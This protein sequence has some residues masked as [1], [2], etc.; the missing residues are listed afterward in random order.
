MAGS[1]RE[2]VILSGELS[3]DLLA[4]ALAAEI[5]K[6]RPDW[7]LVGAGGPH[8]RSAGVDLLYNSTS[9]SAI[10]FAQSVKLIPRLSFALADIKAYIAQRRP[11]RVVLVDFG[12]FNIRV[13]RSAKKC[14]VPVCYYVPPGSWRRGRADSELAHV[15]DLVLTPFPWSAEELRLQGANAHWIGHPLLDIVRPGRSRND[16]LCEAGLSEVEVVFG[17]LPGSRKPELLALTPLMARAAVIIQNRCRR[18]GFLLG[19]ASTTD[20]RLLDRLL[21]S[22]GWIP[23]DPSA[24][25][26]KIRRYKAGAAPAA[27][28]HGAPYDVMAASDIL[29]CCSGTATLEA[30]ILQKPMIIA[31]RTH[32]V[33]Q[34]LEYALGRRLLPRY[35]G[36]PNLLADAEVCPEFLQHRASPENLA[37]EALDIIRRGDRLSD[38]LRG[39][40]E[41]RSI[42][43]EQGASARAAELI[44]DPNLGRGK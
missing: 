25:S 28:V 43:G 29:L 4:G 32:G 36:L 34:A 7:H 9:W 31:Y 6:R 35:I 14:G 12:T 21:R 38:M 22:S 33:A 42:L 23:E 18:A 24:P 3:G 41:I 44:C 10:G 1:P 16:L 26:D 8:L 37:S 11:H 30:A 39:L 40:R 13:A 15:I 27:V 17:L 20:L 19:A 5:R 2:V